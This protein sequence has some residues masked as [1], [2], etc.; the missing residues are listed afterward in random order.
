MDIHEFLGLPHQFRWGGVGG[1]DCTTFAASWCRELT[2]VDPAEDLRGTYRDIEGA[3][4]IIAAH[5]GLVSFVGGRLEPLGWKRVQLPADGD[6]AVIRAPAGFCGD[7]REI[8]AV[9]FGPLWATMAPAGVV[10]RR[11]ESVAVWRAAT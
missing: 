4:A 3:H 10:A 5:G 1:D 7:V 6:I 2:C 9:R 8:T 11:A